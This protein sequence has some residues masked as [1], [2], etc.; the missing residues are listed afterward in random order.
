MIKYSKSFITLLSLLAIGLPLTSCGGGDDSSNGGNKNAVQLEFWHTFGDKVED[1]LSS[2]IESFKTAIKEHDGVDVNVKLVYKGAYKDMIKHITTSFSAGD[3]P[4]IAVAYPDH[5]ADYLEAEGGVSEKYVVN[6]QNYID[7]TSLTFGTEPYI[8]D[9]TDI[10]DFVDAFIEEGTKYTKKGMYSLPYMKSTEVMLYNN[11]AVVQSLKFINDELYK[12]K[13]KATL[14]EGQ[15][16][17]YFSSISW[18]EFLQVAEIIY[19]HRNE[20]DNADIEWPVI[21]DSDSNLFISKLIQNNIGYASI[22]E[23]TQKGIIDFE[24]GENRTKAE[25][26]VSSIV[27]MNKKH[28]LATK[29]SLGEYS[30]NYF[31]QAKA[32]FVIGSSGG[33]G[34]T[35]PEAGSF[36]VGYAKVPASNNNPVYV[37]QGPTL[38]LLTHPKYSKSEADTKKLYG[39]KLLKFLT[40]A[41]NNVELCVSGSEG[42]IPVRKSSYSDPIYFDFIEN[43]GGYADVANVI[44]NDIQGSYFNTAVFKG[45][46]TLRE[47]VGGIITN[48]LSS[49]STLS[50]TAAFDNAINT[51]KTYM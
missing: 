36:D 29:G 11:D 44:N 39:W 43:G 12:E 33:T 31:K 46:S 25:E 20:T 30:S 16:S 49:T 9:K 6:L 24:S 48:L 17:D 32:V 45:S 1:A 40:G 14:T 35:L 3:T 5:V 18:D 41:S 19:N 2:K 7:D 26:F 28:I 4:T 38:T 15:I 50:V 21:Y 47:Q 13:Y 27:A 10:S 34:Y 37:T 42:Y 8:G 51:T 23:T 22:N